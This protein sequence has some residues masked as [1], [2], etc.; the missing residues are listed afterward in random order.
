MR[1]NALKKG[2]L[3]VKVL[4]VAPDRSLLPGQKCLWMHDHQVLVRGY[5]RKQ[6][7]FGHTGALCADSLVVADAS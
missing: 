1:V 4:S 3:L 6:T 5:E 2:L 7:F